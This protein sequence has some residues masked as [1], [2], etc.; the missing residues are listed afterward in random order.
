MPPPSG[1]MPSTLWSIILLAQ[2]G[3]T[4]EAD[5]ALATLCRTYWYPLYVY[6]RKRTGATDRAEDLTQ[7][8]FTRFLEKD[9]LAQAA[10][11]KGR[12]RAYLLAC[13]N[14]FLANSWDHE[15][16]QKRGGGRRVLSLDLRSAEQQY[17]HEPADT[18]SADRLFERRWALTVLEAT[19]SRLRDEFHEARK[20]PL[21]EHLKAALVGEHNAL[22]YADIGRALGMS[23]AAVKKAAQRLRQ[24]YRELLREHVAATVEGP[25]AV[26]DEIRDLFAALR[27]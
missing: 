27:S 15:R 2:D 9:F 21:Y 7:A 25:G 1:H 10:P 18:L 11:E 22:S 23:E 14:H 13:C 4:G 24:R 5:Q 6:I 26:E 12:F 19:L 16:A 17:R 3:S 8:F 20:G